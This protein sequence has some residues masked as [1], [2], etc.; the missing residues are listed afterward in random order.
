MPY[1]P[2]STSDPKTYGLGTNPS[3]PP[4]DSEKK[5]NGCVKKWIFETDVKTT[6]G[7]LPDLLVLFNLFWE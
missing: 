6:A 4:K 2:T 7:S 5:Q 1:K 3:G